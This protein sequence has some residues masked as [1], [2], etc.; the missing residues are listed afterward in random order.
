MEQLFR[1]MDTGG[2]IT[3]VGTAAI[4]MVGTAA[5]TMVGG[6]IVIGGDFHLYQQERER[7][8]IR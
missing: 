6:I 4:T 2:V 7:G 5:I 8:C 1:S 3:T